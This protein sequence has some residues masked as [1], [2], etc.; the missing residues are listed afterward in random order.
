VLGEVSLG[1]TTWRFRVHCDDD[2]H[3]LGSELTAVDE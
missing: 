2:G 3:V 1:D